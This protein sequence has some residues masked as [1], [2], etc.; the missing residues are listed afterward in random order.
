M[1]RFKVYYDMKMLHKDLY[2]FRFVEADDKGARLNGYEGFSPW[3]LVEETKLIVLISGNERRILRVSKYV[4][5]LEALDILDEVY[6]SFEEEEIPKGCT[7]INRIMS[8]LLAS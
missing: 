3:R 7:D 8:F 4:P 6:D 5:V 2:C 1:C